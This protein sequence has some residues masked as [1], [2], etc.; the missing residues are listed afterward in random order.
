MGDVHGHADRHLDPAVDD[1]HPFDHRDHDVP[2]ERGEFPRQD[3][4]RSDRHRRV[5]LRRNVRRSLDHA[6][7]PAA[8]RTRVPPRANTPCPFRTRRPARSIHLSDPVPCLDSRS[9]VV[10]SSTVRR[11]RSWNRFDRQSVSASGVR[12][13]RRCG[14]LSQPRR[15]RE[16]RVEADRDPA[17]RLDVPAHAQ[18]LTGVHHVLRSSRCGIGAVAAI[19]LPRD[20]N[21]TDVS[22]SMNV[23]GYGD[24]SLPSGSD[25]HDIATAT[26]YPVTGGAPTTRSHSADLYIEPNEPQLGVFSRSAR[27]A[28]RRAARLP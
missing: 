19:E 28:P 6:N 13:H 14:E 4:S 9:G 1:G 18:R 25:M 24:A 20:A 7:Q 11:A 10:Y 27:S 26:A 23:W 21:L 15:G 5:R 17:R 16:R 12:S 3:R 22:M 2:W 8:D